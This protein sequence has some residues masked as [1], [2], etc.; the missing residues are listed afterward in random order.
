MKYKSLFLVMFILI[1]NTPFI[2]S[3]NY[4]DPFVKNGVVVS[5]YTV[6]HEYTCDGCSRDDKCYNIGTRI[7][8][9]EWNNKNYLYCNSEKGFVP[10]KVTGETCEN[11]FE[12]QSNG[13]DYTNCAQK[14]G[15]GITKIYNNKTTSVINLFFLEQ[16]T[17][18]F[19]GLNKNYSINFKY[20]NTNLTFL[21]DNELYDF[22]NISYPTN[23]QFVL[24]SISFNNNLIKANM[25][26]IESKTPFNSTEK[27]FK[28]LNCKEGLFIAEDCK[29][30]GE[31]FEMDG[32]SYQIKNMSLLEVPE[33]KSF[34]SITGNVIETPEKSFIGKFLERI[35]EF[36]RRD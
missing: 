30:E 35:R 5:E 22:N 12:C 24:N 28:R 3:A 25:T 34:T 26:L 29:K 18:Y 21:V 15:I 14:T 6:R 36:L 16:E 20:N 10:Q 23:Y 4:P 33:D 19:E 13:C 11:D 2:L 1:V 32:K 7:T 31:S 17:F 8:I 9:N 27:L